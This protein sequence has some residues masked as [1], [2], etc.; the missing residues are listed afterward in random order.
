MLQGNSRVRNF[1][2][3]KSGC[4]FDNGGSQKEIQED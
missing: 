3:E 4:K 2:L 1:F